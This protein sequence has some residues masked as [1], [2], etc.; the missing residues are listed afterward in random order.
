MTIEKGGSLLLQTTRCEAVLYDNCRL[1]FKP[2]PGRGLITIGMCTKHWQAE[3]RQVLA[4]R[5]LNDED[6]TD[7]VDQLIALLEQISVYRVAIVF[8]RKQSTSFGLIVTTVLDRPTL[9][10]VAFT[11][12]NERLGG[13]LIT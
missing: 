4:L 10:R 7:S 3:L 12:I 13:R 9:A 5:D 11:T 1:E 2:Y 6:Q 8:D